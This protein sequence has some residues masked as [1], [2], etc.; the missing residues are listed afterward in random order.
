[1]TRWISKMFVINDVINKNNPW[2]SKVSK[3]GQ[4]YKLLVVAD[5]DADS[6]M[7]NHIAE[8]LMAAISSAYIVNIYT[9]M[10]QNRSFFRNLGFVGHLGCTGLILQN[11]L[12]LAVNTVR[13]R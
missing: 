2:L 12:Y 3:V 8:S 9:N 10:G 13:F 5:G 11:T 4:S 6:D 1:M 7:P